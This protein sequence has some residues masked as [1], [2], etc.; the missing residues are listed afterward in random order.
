MNPAVLEDLTTEQCVELLAAHGVGRIAINDDGLV[1]P[2]EYS[3]LTRF[4]TQCD[5]LPLQGWTP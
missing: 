4:R 5:P 1:L 2:D 3:D